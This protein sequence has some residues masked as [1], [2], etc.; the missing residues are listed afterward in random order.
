MN[1]LKKL[2]LKINSVSRRDNVA[3]IRVEPNII[4][5]GLSPTQRG[6]FFLVVPNS[7]DRITFVNQWINPENP[8]EVLVAVTYASFPTQSA[9][10]LAVNAQQLASS[11]SA[12]GFSA[13]ASSFVSA[14]VTL[15]TPTA[16]SSLQIPTSSINTPSSSI[17]SVPVQL[18]SK[19]LE[20]YIS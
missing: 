3:F 12:I 4:P 20:D 17:S 11:Y 7:G 6:S 19:I 5:N 18:A 9:V 16:P 13:D 14:V 1:Q 15:S 2:T 8:A 10:F